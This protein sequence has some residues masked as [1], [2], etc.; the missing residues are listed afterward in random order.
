[1]KFKSYI[2]FLLL[3]FVIIQLV[4]IGLAYGI[5]NSSSLIILI[6]VIVLIFLVSDLSN[7]VKR[8]FRIIDDFFEAVKYR[9]FSR[10][11]PE[12][13][14]PKDIRFLHKGFNEVNRTIKE[15]NAK[16]EVQNVYI[17]KILE[18]VEVGIIAY[19]LENGKVLWS[20]KTFSEIIDYPSFKNIGFIEKRDPLLHE[21]IF[22]TY[23]PT[24]ET[25]SISINREVQKVLIS[26]TLF[27]I[28]DESFKLIVLQN[29]EDTLNKNE[30][31]AWKK[32][33]SVMT[34]EIMN[35]ITPIAS[36]AET[37][38][39]Q[40]QLQIE[41]PKKN[42]VDSKDIFNG[43]HTIKSRSEGLLKFAK[44][45]RNLNKESKLNLKKINISNLFSNIKTLME[46]SLKS[47]G[48]QINFEVQSKRMEIEVDEYLIEQV[49]INLILNAKDAV[50]EKPNPEISVKA[51]YTDN[52]KVVLSVMDNGVGIPK[53]L[54][55][56]IFIPFF[57]NKSTGSGIGLSL[58]KKIMLL[59]K[60][61]IKVNSKEGE[62][63]EFA[64]MFK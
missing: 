50:K 10:W 4:L 60:G 1:M 56:D 9:D 5:Y 42:P 2:G 7:F 23:Y 51:G 11:F 40:L 55:E 48:I 17:Q 32:L 31:E 20:N 61:K 30:S 57:T 58:C 15:V 46:P 8:R 43:I 28:E 18:L 29:I 59:H 3:R 39:Q 44:T 47:K 6:A 27:Q 24:P 14:G 54:M 38:S 45:Y 34:H 49:L 16:S 21:S 35:S 53:D 37:L 12:D 33:L 52:H 63:T 22:E 62:F 64:L 13:R 25:L 19:Q 41:N 26:E 36:L